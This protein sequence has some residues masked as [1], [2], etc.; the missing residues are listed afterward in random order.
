MSS[1]AKEILKELNLTGKT[2]VFETVA[3]PIAEEVKNASNQKQYVH[4]VP[5]MPFM[6]KGDVT[7]KLLT[8]MAKLSPTHGAVI[9]SIRR[10]VLGGQFEV[11]TKKTP[12][13]ARRKEQPRAVSLEEHEAYTDWLKSWVKP[14]VLLNTLNRVY[15]N[16][17][18]YGNAWLEIVLTE[19][20]GERKA[21]IYSH[22]AESVLYFA[23]LPGMPR[24]PLIS[25]YWYHPTNY[26]E[27]PVAVPLWPKFA[28]DEAGTRR[29]FLHLKWDVAGRNWYGEPYWL[30]A[31]YYIYMEMQSGQYNVEGF[32]NK[33]TPEAFIETFEGYG[34]EMPATD[35]TENGQYAEGA[36]GFLAKMEK[37]YSNKG[38]KRRF[39]HR[40]APADAQPSKVHQFAPNTDHHYHRAMVEIAESQAIKM[41][42]WH[43]AL[44]SIATPGKLGR[45]QEFKDAFNQKWH[46]VIKPY[47]AVLCDPLN[48]AIDI[49]ADWLGG[50]ATELVENYSLG[51]ANLY[52]DMLKTEKEEGTEESAEDEGEEG[53]VLSDQNQQTTEQE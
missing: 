46:T 14:N 33:F 29:T 35:V 1:N 6:A 42:D 32:A 50:E 2:G 40:N 51:L 21:A 30:A 3:D 43:A 36:N 5:V 34:G 13:F 52:E 26:G 15:D 27:E 11:T 38:K 17:A 16:Y 31:L 49:V 10:Y 45:S 9:N 28:E 47:Q 23:T 8:R 48:E 37:F 53:A 24:I 44:M 22:D 18:K 41:H 39:L 4:S 25:P 20:A 19:V 12:G 7:F